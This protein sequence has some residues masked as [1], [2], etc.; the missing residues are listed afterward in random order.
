MSGAEVKG[1][2]FGF[3]LGLFQSWYRLPE[4]GCLTDLSIADVG[5]FVLG[6]MAICWFIGRLIHKGDRSKGIRYDD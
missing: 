2:V 1:L 5:A 4:G 3:F 6:S